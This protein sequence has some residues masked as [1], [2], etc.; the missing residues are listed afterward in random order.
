MSEFDALLNETIKEL[1]PI[2]TAIDISTFSKHNMGY[3][4]YK[5]GG[6]LN[7]FMGEKRR[8]QKTFDFVVNYTKCKSSIRLLDIGTLIAILPIMFSKIGI[9][10]IHIVENFSFYGNSLNKL[11]SLLEDKYKIHIHDIDVLQGLPFKE[12]YEFDII[13]LL[14][15]IEHFSSSPQKLLQE[16]YEV[17]NTDGRFIL[18]TPNVASAIKRLRFLVRGMPP[19][20]SIE[21]YF[22][23]EPPF[24]GHNREYNPKELQKVLKLTGF[25]IVQ[26]ALFNLGDFKILNTKTKLIQSILPMI[27]KSLRDYIWVVAKK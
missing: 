6:L 12:K 8:Y 17:L 7:A 13:T 19:Y 15:V 16:I 9:S 20:P 26:M 27:F 18:D 4:R 23:S 11:R 21:D 5:S 25:E 2:V 24:T 3:K 22:F 10:E 1:E 14:A